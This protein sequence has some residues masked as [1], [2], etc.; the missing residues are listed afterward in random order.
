MNYKVI[1]GRLTARTAIHIGSGQGNGY[2]DALIWRGGDGRP[3]IPGTTIAGVLRSLATRISPYLAL[4]GKTV[5]DALIP[6]S[7][8]GN[9]SCG[10]VVCTLFG[11]ITPGEEQK[12]ANASRLRVFNSTLLNEEA[13]SIRDGVGIDRITGTAS[14]ESRAKFDQEVLS[15]GSVFEF[16]LELGSES[17]IDEQI[18]AAVLTEWKAGRVWLGGKTNRGL[19]AFDLEF[20]YREL[21]ISQKEGLLS[22]LRTASPWE[23]ARIQ[24][25]WL[26]DTL[27]DIQIVA[28]PEALGYPGL[29]SWVQITGELHADG[30]LLVN[31]P[32]SQS[33]SGFDHAPML[34]K[35]G[36]W[37]QPILS[38]ASIR[39]VI[40]SHAEKLART[41]STLNLEK[42]ESFLAACPACTPI[43]NNPL[44]PLASCQSLL[45]K[46]LEE[47]DD[48]HLCLAC[49]LFGS[50]LQKSKVIIE[51]GDFNS[52]NGD[53]VYKMLDFLA[54]DRF[55]GGGADGAKFDALALVNPVFNIKI[56]IYDPE[57]WELGWIG[58]VLR[59][60]VC[61]LLSFGMGRSK[62][63]GRMYLQNLDATLGHLANTDAFHSASGKRNSSLYFEQSVDILSQA[64]WVSVFCNK[65]STFNR[66]KMALP[67][68]ATD[69]Y[70]AENSLEGIYPKEVQDGKN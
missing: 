45:P 28:E 37:K 21:D 61:G 67:S 57:P 56:F 53:P 30:L 66:E 38:G 33:L 20:D 44:N 47:A 51:D 34:S 54:I 29:G 25:N 27:N 60:M 10:C 17:A 24:P 70:F 39:G 42:G 59:D 6:V 4:E 14:R 68:L 19:G 5:C 40:R 31:D 18:L 26:E 63:M 52:K 49:R 48:S 55:T 35:G 13:V 16:R 15:P 50:T 62:G 3:L 65:V 58:L 36:D 46:D 7:N 64:D 8:N 32:T 9:A 1:Y 12:R 69:Y 2:I 23:A 43:E 11:D 22:Y 41:W